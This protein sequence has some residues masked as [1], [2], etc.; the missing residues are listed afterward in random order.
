MEISQLKSNPFS[1]R[2]L[3]DSICSKPRP[4]DLIEV[5]II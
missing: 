5:D 3:S 4:D 2:N 1:V